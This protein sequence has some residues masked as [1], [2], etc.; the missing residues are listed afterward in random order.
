MFKKFFHK[1][2]NEAGKQTQQTK[3]TVINPVNGKVYPISESPDEVFA[4]KMLGDGF[5]VLPDD[6]GVYSPV[7]GTV[8]TLFPT[9]HAVGLKA[10]DGTEI[11]VHMGID[12]VALNGV[13]FTIHVQEGEHV[14]HA[15]KLAT[16][17]L[18]YLENHQLHTDVMVVFTDM[19]KIEKFELTT[20]GQ[21]AQGAEIGSYKIKA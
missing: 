10:D 2:K 14:T 13:P 18:D 1:Q 19:E 9:K 6:G 12:T 21:L 20:Q 11:L 17:D 8:I 16:I 4:Q 7:S 15:S 3:F 5:A